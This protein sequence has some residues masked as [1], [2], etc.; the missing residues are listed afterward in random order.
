MQP[1][2]YTDTHAF[3]KGGGEMG[4]LIRS[5][6]WSQT[7]LG[8]PDTWSPSLQTT[9]GIILNS[10]FPM[11][12][13][14]GH[15][16]TCFYNDAYRPSLGN[17]GKHPHALG[18]SAVDI[19]P[20]IWDIVKPLLDQV[21]SGGGAT[22][23]EDLL[24][25][26]YRDGKIDDIYWTFSY[27]P[28]IDGT[29]K[30]VGVLATCMETTEKVANL[31]QL[32]ENKDQLHFAVEAAELGTWDFNPVTNCF[33]GNDRLRDWFG[34]PPKAEIDLSSAVSVMAER[35]R[36]RVS[37]AIRRAMMYDSGGSYDID[38]TIIHPKTRQ[39]RRVRAKGRAW[40]NDDHIAYRFNGTLQDITQQEKIKEEQQKLITIMEASH[41]FISMAA[42]DTSIQYGNPAA[43]AM[44]GWDTFTGKTIQDCV[45]PKD[46]S[47]ARKL[48]AELPETGHFSQEIRFVNVRTG[49]P[50]WLE[51]N[52]VTIMD[53]TS[54]EMTGLAT[55]SPNIMERKK[56]EQNLRESERRFRSLIEEAP[57][58]TCLFVGR[59]LRV[60]VVNSAMTDHW[61]KGSSLL[62]RNL[63]DILPELDGQP[64]L[65]ILD[66]VFT[67]GKTYE[68]KA[69]NAKLEVGGSLNTYYF[70]LI[71]KPLLDAT[72]EVYAIMAMSVDVTRQ[73][74]DQNEL[75]ASEERYRDL[76]AELEE[77]VRE[78]TGE[79]E[80]S[81]EELAASN[82]ELVQANEEMAEANRLFIQS[83]QNL[84]QFAFVASHDLQEPLR[85]IQSFG[86]LL[87]DQYGT[88][89]GEGAELLERMQS[90]ANRMSVLI[91]D[92]LTFSRIANRKNT[93]ELVFIRD[94]VN[95]VLNDLDLVITETNAQVIVESMPSL[96]GDASQLGQLFLNLLSNALKFHQPDTPPII[97]IRCQKVSSLNLPASIKPTHWAET[98]HR[99]D[100]ADN[101]IGFDPK[102][103]DRIFQVFQRLHGR[104]HYSG[105]GIGLAICE[106]VVVNHGG[107]ITAISQP[108]KGST[109]TVYLPV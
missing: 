96:H 52:A 84:E 24:I 40:F 102:Y 26:F 31:K 61:G 100:I 6:D 72:G 101:G 88:Q 74:M 49:N 16:L 76:S 8:T 59:E 10:R 65:Q 89:L 53:A 79:L 37:D 3:L 42:T 20:E 11:F 15:Q 106:K 39:E 30:R 78:R 90:A 107:A 82:E 35:D 77:Q 98:Y 22:W 47:I 83:N 68:Q 14:W 4:H 29:G 67:S 19:W 28:V 5:F 93:V 66:N 95:T 58:A 38:Y 87:Q 46:W 55:V 32:A 12:L 108:G 2:Q 1:S 23:S 13:L 36:Q 104:Q 56:I 17:E 33:T 43:L 73:V 70:D 57:V 44:L 51:W 45:Y 41:E 81:N 103:I 7:A 60:E 94:I 80:T 71:F 18:K 99:I 69:A 63:A 50:F 54:G 75:K 105:T 91:K 62:G 64:F 34:L 92:L 86:N 9:L 27:S 85:K 25:P 48:L 97:K 109:F 21:L